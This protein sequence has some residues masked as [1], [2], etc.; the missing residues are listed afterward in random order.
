M[1]SVINPQVKF[2]RVVELVDTPVL[3]TGLAR[4]VGSNPISPTSKATILGLLASLVT[5]FSS[6]FVATHVA[7]A[8]KC[9]SVKGVCIGIKRVLDD[10]LVLGTTHQTYTYSLLHTFQQYQHVFFK[11]N[12]YALVD[13]FCNKCNK[14]TK[15]RHFLMQHI[16]LCILNLIRKRT[17]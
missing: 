8:R 12:M 13:S 14:Y 6:K 9:C 7:L 4:G 16:H 1:K 15:I 3:G 10:W 2:G 5:K 17:L 11:I